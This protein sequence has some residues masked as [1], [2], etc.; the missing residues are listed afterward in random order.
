MRLDLIA[1]DMTQRSNFK[2]EQ[3]TCVFVLA[4]PFP[5]RNLPHI[6]PNKP[7]IMSYT[8]DGVPQTARPTHLNAKLAQLEGFT[9]RIP[10]DGDKHVSVFSQA[11]VDNLD[12]SMRAGPR[13]PT[14]IDD[15]VAR[16]RI[17]HFDHERIPER[18]VH[19]RG[20]GAHGVFK[21]HT[22]LADYTTAKILTQVG[23]ET[24]TFVRFSTVLG[25]N[26]AAETAREDIV[27]NNIPVFFIQDGIKFVDLIHS[28]KPAP[29]IHLPQAQTAHDNFWDFISLTPESVFMSLFSLSDYT[30]PR[31]YRMLKGFGVNTFVLVNREGKRTFVKYHWKP[32]LGQH[33]LVWDECLKLG[34]QDPDYLRRDLAD[35]IEAGAYPKYELGVQLISEEQELTFDFDILDCTKIVP[36]E[37]VPITW[38]GTMELNRNPTNYFAETEQV[39]FCTSN[40]VPG[41]DYSNDPM[42]QLR[43]FS[44]FDT[45]ISR[46][47]GVNFNELPINR[48]VCPFISTIRDGQHQERIFA[49][50]NYYPNRFQ[51]PNAGTEHGKGQNYAHNEA[52]I[53]EATKPKEGF[54]T[55]APYKV[56]GTRGRLRPA[57]FDN[58]YS[59]AQLFWNSMSDVEKEH[60]IEAA[61]FELGRCDDREIQRRN[62]LRWNNVDHNLALAVASAFDIDVPEP[63]IKNHGKKTDGENSLS[64][65]SANNPSSA[66]GRRIAVFALDGFDSL[67]VSGMVAAITALGSIPNVVGSRKGPCYPRGTKKGDSGASGVINSNFTLET[68]RS[69]LFDG[70]FIP[71]GDENFVKELSSGRGL[72]WIREAFAHFKTIGAVGAS[73]P[74]FAH[75]ALPGITDYKADL[76]KAYSSKNGVVLAE[77]LAGDEATLWQKI[78]GAKDLTGFGAEF[79]DALSK[80]RHWY[81]EGAKDVAF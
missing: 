60:I 3:H 53:A 10:L 43:N 70:L 13:G 44:Y 51:T 8:G 77:N 66:V 45:Q 39:A 38:V 35:A 9:T 31:S 79:V 56:E 47:G 74:V 72:H 64:L 68:A 42:L 6:R 49:G 76:S 29:Q 18:V 21:L 14:S 37:L 5:I 73:V 36:E 25:Q 58:H 52:A 19:A 41:M 48:S 34:G 24:P 26:G 67:Q 4:S 61:I 55:P 78:K 33:G 57:R 69:T 32:H 54:L 50:P 30:I 2:D 22:S 12:T 1:S 20:V 27:G 11:P 40:I 63:E 23:Q 7:G 46:L 59:Q 62:I 15:P 17:S 71:D 81:R 80:H 28:G 75:K 16:E 65:L